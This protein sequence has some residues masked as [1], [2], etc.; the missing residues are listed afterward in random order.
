GLSSTLAIGSGGTGT[1]TA[2]VSQLLYGG[3]GGI[4]QSVATT[5]AS[6][7]GSASCS[8]FTIIGSSPITISATGGGGGSDPFTHAQFGQSATT[9]AFGIGTTSPFSQLAVSTST[10]SSPF[11]KLFTIASTTGAELFTVLGNGFTGI[12]T[13]S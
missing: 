1:T 5:T 4:Y 10:Q 2:P 6:C 7:S 11:T 3:T 13:S 8:S 12:G 9:T